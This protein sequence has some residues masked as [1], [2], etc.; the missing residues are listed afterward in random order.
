MNIEDLK[1]Y[2]IEIPKKGKTIIDISSDWCAPCQILS[3]VL[4]ELSEEGLFNLIQVNIDNNRSLA[5]RLNI[6][7]VPTLLCFKDGKLIEKNIVIQGQ[8][9]VNNGV[10]IGAAGELVLKEIV[11]IIGKY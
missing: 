4:E 11:K 7:A 5:K 3:S 6:Y 9:V 1:P 8:T 10:M 2:G